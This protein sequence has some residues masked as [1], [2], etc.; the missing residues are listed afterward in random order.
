MKNSKQQGQTKKNLIGALLTKQ[1]QMQSP[2]ENHL[3]GFPPSIPKSQLDL[4]ITSQKNPRLRRMFRLSNSRPKQG[5]RSKINSLSCETFQ[6]DFEKIISKDRE[7]SNKRKGR[8]KK[9]SETTVGFYKPERSMNNELV[10]KANPIIS[11]RKPIVRPKKVIMRGSTADKV[12]SIKRA[13]FLIPKEDSILGRDKVHKRFQSF[14]NGQMLP[15]EAKMPSILS[16]KQAKSERVTRNFFLTHTNFH[17]RKPKNQMYSSVKESEE[18]QSWDLAQQI[19]SESPFFKGPEEANSGYQSTT[20]LTKIRKKKN[21]LKTAYLKMKKISKNAIE[22]PST[23][24]EKIRSSQSKRMNA[25]RINSMVKSDYDHFGSE[26]ENKVRNISYLYNKSGLLRNQKKNPLELLNPEEANKK[27]ASTL[28]EI[29][30]ILKN[31]EFPLLGEELFDLIA[32][33]KLSHF[34][35]KKVIEKA[36]DDLHTRDDCKDFAK[37]TCSYVKNFNVHGCYERNKSV[38]ILKWLETIKAKYKKDSSSFNNS[39]DYFRAMKDILAFSNKEVIEAEKM[40]CKETSMLMETLYMDNLDY[41]QSMF[42]YL[43]GFLK[44]VQKKHKGELNFMREIGEKKLESLQYDNNV[45]EE[46]NLRLKQENSDH[47]AAL[48]KMRSKLSNDYVLIRNLRSELGYFEEMLRVTRIEN[49]KIT[50]IIRDMNIEL[51]DLDHDFDNAGMG[52]SF[53]KINQRLYEIERT[54]ERYQEELHALNDVKRQRIEEEKKV[55]SEKQKLEFM[56]KM[57][58]VLGVESS[59]VEFT[60]ASVEV[61]TEAIPPEGEEKETQTDVPEVE[62]TG[63]QTLRFECKACVEKEKI[64]L[65]MDV[66]DRKKI[67]DLNKE[68]MHIIEEKEE[69]EKEKND[70]AKEIYSIEGQM[71]QIEKEKEGFFEKNKILKTNVD[72]L[73]SKLESEKNKFEEM[74]KDYSAQQSSDGGSTSM[75]GSRRTMIPRRLGSPSLTIQQPGGALTPSNF[76]RSSTQFR[77][78]SDSNLLPIHNR[79]LTRGDSMYSVGFESAFSNDE[80]SISIASVIPDDVSV[81]DLSE[82]GLR[83]VRKIHKALLKKLSEMSKD[84][85]LFNFYKAKADMYMSYLKSHMKRRASRRFKSRGLGRRGIPH[86]SAFNMR[87]T[88]SIKEGRKSKKNKKLVMMIELSTSLFKE[89]M[90]MIKNSYIPKK[91]K[92]T[93]DITLVKEIYKI[94]HYFEETEESIGEIKINFNVFVFKYLRSR[95]SHKKIVSKKYKYVSQTTIHPNL[96]RSCYTV[97][98]PI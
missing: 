13:S 15:P 63:V 50:Q 19:I 82:L 22:S 16:R 4:H 93:R 56:H 74:L 47:Q 96:L 53:D 65:R 5:F 73:K 31:S 71:S 83:K 54:H 70:I 80:E 33:M 32:K 6:E 37:K 91:K 7:R 79:L 25:D 35:K 84:D 44:Q 89:V 86:A 34:N 58:D 76:K 14:H 78:V 72:S 42:D 21:E 77:K 36:N 40:R 38:S 59:E 24:K 43:G 3:Y 1:K 75:A 45:L 69:L 28:K 52:M 39:E 97:S 9:Y 68:K 98:T 29:R 92:L 27:K 81:S 67:R 10:V 87:S 48:R 20:I 26:L 62:E 2:S 30:G 55:M 66:E 88:S 12:D 49:Q 95:N 90:Q 41:I 8:R 94:Y 51:K 61:Q 64:L 23:L 11:A 46:N 17:T 57:G 85:E 60:T 18:A